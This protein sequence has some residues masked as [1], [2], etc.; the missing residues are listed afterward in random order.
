MH[1]RADQKAEKM[2]EGK[3]KRKYEKVGRCFRGRRRGGVVS[4]GACADPPEN[5]PRSWREGTKRDRAR[6]R[7]E[8][9]RGRERERVHLKMINTTLAPRAPAAGALKLGREGEGARERERRLIDV[10]DRALGTRPVHA[11]AMTLPPDFRAS[12]F[13]AVCY[14]VIRIPHAAFVSVASAREF[15]STGPPPRGFARPLVAMTP[16]SSV[17][18]ATRYLN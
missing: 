14:L 17:L 11:Y 8:Q 10:A 1:K 2:K 16:L 13:A 12:G 9:S 15:R 7:V 5:P 18:S 6:E 3:K 4:S